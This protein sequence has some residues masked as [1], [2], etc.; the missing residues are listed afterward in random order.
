MAKAVRGSPA[1]GFR[2]G[3]ENCLCFGQ[4][5]NPG[6]NP[7]HDIFVDLTLN[8]SLHKQQNNHQKGGEGYEPGLYS[9]TDRGW[10]LTYTIH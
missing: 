3:L 2:A 1:G 8:W 7:L 9:Q 6:S 10:N 5:L 4:V